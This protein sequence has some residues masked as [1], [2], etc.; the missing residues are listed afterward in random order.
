MCS[1]WGFELT[2]VE[3]SNKGAAT[4]LVL[5]AASVAQAQEP[6]IEASLEQWAG[7]WTRTGP[8]SVHLGRPRTVAAEL[9]G[10]GRGVK[11]ELST[12]TAN[13]RF[14]LE[15]VQARRH[16]DDDGDP[17]TPAYNDDND[18]T[19]TDTPVYVPAQSVN[20]GDEGTVRFSLEG[21]VFAERVRRN[22]FEDDHGA[23]QFEVVAGGTKG[24]SSV[25]V[26]IT[27]Q[28]TWGNGDS[29]YFVVPDLTATDRSA[30]AP[31]RMSAVMSRSSGNFPDGHPSNRNCD[32]RSGDTAATVR[33]CKLINVAPYISRFDLSGQ[34]VGK[35]DLVDRTKLIDED[36]EQLADVPIG[37]VTLTA[38]AGN[39]IL[40][41]D[42]RPARFAGGLAGNVRFAVAS[43][44]LR[45]G[46]IVY[47][48]DDGNKQPSARETFAVRGS[49]A[50]T[51]RPLK[52]GTWTIRYRP[53]GKDD[54]THDSSFTV[55][56]ATDFKDGG[57]LDATATEK[58]A[59]GRDYAPARKAVVSTLKL[60]GI[61]G[62]PAKAYAVAPIGSTDTS[63]V[64]ITC[65]SGMPCG[66]FLDC[67][68]SDGKRYFGDAGVTVPPD[69]TVRLHQT[70]L[71]DALG[72]IEGDTWSGRLACD[73]LS[74]AP[75]SVQVLTRA[76]GVLVNNTYVGE[77]GS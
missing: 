76:A 61:T 23:D 6:L 18:P 64:R 72:L 50:T 32:P 21:A 53:N 49:A 22:D 66:V 17:N 2:S 26:K 37:T 1:G 47:I 4:A 24:D 74:T 60:N 52:A 20:A 46:D 34:R 8:S 70:A 69:G 36:G 59:A 29:I 41:R 43:S 63:N 38:A 25:T 77:G 75:I 45:E 57:N 14:R 54:L 28:S 10:P 16:V 48:D 7:T 42:G 73:V 30:T 51:G 12:P 33:G 55:S 39:A 13:P 62:T 71:N 40:D 65:E 35:I 19:T 15:Y 67:R 68:D 56:A 11:L 3:W 58:T 9:F 31:V 44:K 27:A 5:F